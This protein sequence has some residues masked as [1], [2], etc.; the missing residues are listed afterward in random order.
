MF[1]AVFMIQLA[2]LPLPTIAL[3]EATIRIAN[4]YSNISIVIA[5]LTAL[6]KARGS[7]F[8]ITWMK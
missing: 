4:M 8:V 3:Q 5:G 1:A 6:K 2:C 7:F